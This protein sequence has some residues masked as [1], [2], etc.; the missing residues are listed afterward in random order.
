MVIMT[1]I[2]FSSSLNPFIWYFLRFAVPLTCVVLGICI[3]TKYE[4]EDNVGY[5][6]YDIIEE[7]QESIMVIV[8]K[9]VIVNRQL[10]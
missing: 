6:I 3:L 1:P 4:K 10:N 7:R 8:N 9:P 5:T 2:L